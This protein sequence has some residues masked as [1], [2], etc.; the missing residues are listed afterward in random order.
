VLGSLVSHEWGPQS[1][2]LPNYVSILPRGLFRSG[3]P[4]AGFLG[5]DHA[6]LRVGSEGADDQAGR[7]AIENLA[8]PDGVTEAQLCDRIALLEQF[9]SPFLANHQGPAAEGH[10]SA[11]GRSLKL[12]EPSAVA[13]FDL[14]SESAADRDR[15]GRSQF[16]Q[17]CLLARRLIERG[18]PFV[19]VTLGGWDTHVNNFPAVQGLC[20]TLGRAWSALLADLDQRGL[21]ES[22][23]IVWMGEFGRTPVINPQQGRDHYPKA[24]S[25]VLGGAGLQGGAVVGR[26]SADGLTV[27]DRP[28]STPDLL[29]TILLA[30]GLDPAKQNMSNV[31]RPIR[32]ADPSAQPVREIL[33]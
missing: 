3:I 12:M 18:V 1:G 17:G 7:L 10:R 31:G 13:A 8:R 4:P 9:E 16:G 24:W 30:M 6:P 19:E 21:L 5:S 25:V 2:E 28:V 20:S 26:T 33:A 11:Y 15:Y 14:E 23:V 27:E 32:L 22:T 29:A